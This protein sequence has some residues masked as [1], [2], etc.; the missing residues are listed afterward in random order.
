MP[1]TSTLDTSAQKVTGEALQ[2]AVSDLLDLS[3][4][5]KQMHWNVTGKNFRSLHLQLDEVVAFARTY[6]DT[7]AERAVA[8]G[9]TPQGRAGDVASGSGLPEAKS[10][11][12]SDSEVVTYMISCYDALADRFRQRIEATE[13]PD[14]VTQDL[15]ISITAELEKM[16]WMFQAENAV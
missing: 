12:V 9:V 7:C 14:P 15:F 8:I 4:V 11:W 16:R 13:E 2:G 6:A 5:G 3:L 1:V 10:G